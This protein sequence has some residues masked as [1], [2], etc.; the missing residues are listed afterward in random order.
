MSDLVSSHASEYCIRYSDHVLHRRLEDAGRCSSE[1]LPLELPVL[2]QLP[3]KI[4]DAGGR[5][6]LPSK[7]TPG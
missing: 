2:W 7:P 4:E 3:A 1:L 6:C 5:V